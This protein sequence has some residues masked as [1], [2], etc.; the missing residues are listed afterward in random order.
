MK[1]GYHNITSVIK[2]HQS[3][4][5]QYLQES[6]INIFTLGTIHLDS[7]VIMFTQL[8]KMPHL[9]I[10]HVHIDMFL[11]SIQSEDHID[12][13]LLVE[14]EKVLS[15]NHTIK[16]FL[17]ELSDLPFNSLINSLLTGVERNDII[18]FFSLSSDYTRT[19]LLLIQ[20]LLKNNQTLQAVQLDISIKRILQSL[21]ISESLTALNINNN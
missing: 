20:E 2:I 13:E 6:Y 16:E 8:F 21:C 3:S 19:K 12:N 18:Q 15:T 7:F 4:L 9:G 1:A 5:C 10:L 14:M 11:S 17:I